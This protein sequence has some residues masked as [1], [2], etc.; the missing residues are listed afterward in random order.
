[1]IYGQSY[2]LDFNEYGI[3]NEMKSKLVESTVDLATIGDKL[4][5]MPYGI[6]PTVVFAYTPL[7]NQETLNDVIENGWTWADYHAIG[8]EIKSQHTDV[9]MT[10]YNMR[11]DDRIYRTMTSQKGEWMM[12]SDLSVEIG[13]TNSVEAMTMI[14]DMF[15]DGVIGHID[16]GDYKGLMKNGQIAAQ[17]HGFLSVDK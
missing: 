11:G 5:A 10:A 12:A 9:Y 16:T 4:V 13:N 17:V 8:L 15:D 1:M 2:F 3:T 6:A 7:W 14:K